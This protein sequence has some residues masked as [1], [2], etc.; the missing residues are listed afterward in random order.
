[1]SSFS[2]LRMGPEGTQEVIGGCF[3]GPSILDTRAGVGE[4]AGT[5]GH[6][7]GAIVFLGG[8]IFGT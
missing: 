5:R 3:G 2:V 6:D 1:M 8:L 7:S 4:G